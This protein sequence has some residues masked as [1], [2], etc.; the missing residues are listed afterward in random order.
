MAAMHE[1][2][3][4]LQTILWH[5]SLPMLP[6]IHKK[7]NSWDIERNQYYEMR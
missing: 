5:W 3:L 6:E 7:I 2:T 1:D 4:Y